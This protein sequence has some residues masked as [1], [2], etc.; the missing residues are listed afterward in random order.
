MIIVD[1]RERL[2]LRILHEL[3]ADLGVKRL[4]VGDFVIG[5]VCIER[6]TRK[7]FV[8]SIIDKRIFN[9]LKSMKDNCEKSMVI[10]EG[11]ED[12]YSQRNVHPNAIRGAIA[13]IVVDFGISII[14][15][16]SPIETAKM[17]IAIDRKIEKPKKE[18]SLHKRKPISEHE[19]QVYIV[20]SLPEVGS[21]LAKNML[22]EFGTIKN[23]FNAS[24]K[25]LLR[26]EGIGKLKAKR[27]YKIINLKYSDES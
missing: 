22:K 10:I 11:S 2:I 1:D 18:V 5:D 24:E 6:K 20:S 17:L 4:E 3:N 23:V 12:I 26:V 13:S 16:E 15:T 27:I 8:N 7:D 21:L 19:L 25:E 9:Q 14:E